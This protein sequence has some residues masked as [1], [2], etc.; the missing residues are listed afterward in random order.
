[1]SKPPRW[2]PLAQEIAK[3]FCICHDGFKSR[4]MADPGCRCDTIAEAIEEG[5]RRGYEAGLERAA[6]ICK[7]AVEMLGLPDSPA[8]EGDDRPT[9][10]KTALGLATAIRCEKEE[11]PC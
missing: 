9:V 10:K 8:Y 2:W 7:T 1:M 5:I 11:K 6:E 3:R 4:N